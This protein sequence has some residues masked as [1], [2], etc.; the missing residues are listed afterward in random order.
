M[1]GWEVVYLYIFARY[2]HKARILAFFERELH[3]ILDLGEHAEELITKFTHMTRLRPWSGS[4]VR[5]RYR[6]GKC[7]ARRTVRQMRRGPRQP[8]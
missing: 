2:V 7:A 4:R 3:T 5:S 1:G 6:S 8:L